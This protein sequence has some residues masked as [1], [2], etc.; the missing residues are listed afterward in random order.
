MSDG[1]RVSE[2]STMAVPNVQSDC[3]YTQLELICKLS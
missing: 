1:V 3:A 2:Y